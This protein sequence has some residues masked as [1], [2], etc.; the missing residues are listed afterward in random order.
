MSDNKVTVTEA[1]RE[2]P[3]IQADRLDRASQNR[4]MAVMRTAGWYSRPRGYLTVRLP[5][6]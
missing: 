4:I 1:A 2:A 6:T 5:A 3:S